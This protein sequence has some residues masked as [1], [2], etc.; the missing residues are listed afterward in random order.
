[1]DPPVQS[2]KDASPL[3][4]DLERND[5]G[6]FLMN[7]SVRDFSWNGLSVTVKD[8]QTKQARD[9]ISNITGDVQQGEYSRA[10]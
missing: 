1:M 9:L 6:L 10:N 7:R 5:D 8:R 2:S 3:G 4:P